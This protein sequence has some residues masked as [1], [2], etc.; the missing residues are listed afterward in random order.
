[1]DIRVL[2]EVC[3]TSF[4]SF[5]FVESVVWFALKVTL[6][7]SFLY[8]VLLVWHV[9]F[10]SSS[11]MPR[12]LLLILMLKICWSDYGGGGII[13]MIYTSPARTQLI[14]QIRCNKYSLRLVT[15][16][17]DDNTVLISISSATARNNEM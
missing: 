10:Y 9:V 5:F 6:F 15:T 17:D 4:Q 16:Q 12:C 14:T 8:S 2:A 13:Q 7:K 11:S 3:S 1:M